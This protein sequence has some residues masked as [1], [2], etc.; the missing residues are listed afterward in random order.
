MSLYYLK[1]YIILYFFIIYFSFIKTQNDTFIQ[2]K[3]LFNEY[4]L[5]YNN[6]IS[7]IKEINDKL[8]DIKYN[9]ILL[10]KFNNLKKTNQIIEKQ[11]S[12]LYN[13]LNSN[14]CDK[15]KINEGLN[16]L[17]KTLLKFDKKCNDLNHAFNKFDM[18]KINLIKIIKKVLNAL[19]ILTIIV[20]LIAGA[21][22]LFIIKKQKKYRKIRED[23]SEDQSFD[24]E[25][26][27]DF[28]SL[29]V[30]ST[31]NYSNSRGKLAKKK[32]KQKKRII[33]FV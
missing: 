16:E 31:E 28:Y 1:K 9:F 7:K 26:D 33:K 21:I 5:N 13:E 17:N 12:E 10:I 27:R 23:Y 15:I 30:K 22:T 2:E 24:N 29:K 6:S 20:F 19:I 18:T 3:Q 32:K 4:V 25:G 11:I 14:T 8:S